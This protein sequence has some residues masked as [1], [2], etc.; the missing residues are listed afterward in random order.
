MKP[1]TQALFALLAILAVTRISEAKTVKASEMTPAL[2]TEATSG[3]AQDLKIEFRQG[4]E[5]PVS[6]VAQGDLIE[7]TRPEVSYVRVKKD[8]WL[9]MNQDKFQISWDGTHFRN[10]QEVL[11]G[12]IQAGASN[13]N[14][15][16]IA[17]ALNITFNAKIK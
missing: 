1:T 12:S 7:T 11:T 9:L 5:L 4:D 17:N 2:W 13:D 10:I 14:G 3:K 15:N 8:F 16:G 6:L